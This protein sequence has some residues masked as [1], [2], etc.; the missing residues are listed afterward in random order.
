MYNPGADDQL[1]WLELHNE[2]AVNM[3]ISQWRIDGIEF[4]FPSR[5]VIPAGGYLVVAKSPTAL[6]SATGFSQAL[7]PYTGQLSNGGEQL[8]LINNNQRVMDAL[9]YDDAGEWPVGP[10]GSGASLAKINP[11]GGTQFV[12]NW[13]SSTQIGG[14]PGARNFTTG[15]LTGPTE[16]LIAFD[17]NWRYDQSGTD[18]GTDWLDAGF[19]P[20]DPNNDGSGLDA[21]GVGAGLLGN[22]TASLAEPIRT[23]V[24]LGVPTYYMR[25]EFNYEGNTG[26][27][28]LRL[29]SIVDDGAVFYL[30]GQEVS[31]FNMP[32]GTIEF[33]TP[34]VSAVR[35]ATNSGEI[36]IPTDAL[37]QGTNVL[38]VEVHQAVE[39]LVP[40]E[41]VILT[42]GGL[43]LVEE[44]P[45][46]P[47]AGSPAPDNLARLGTPFALDQLSDF[48]H[49]I[50]EINDGLYGNPSSW[51]GNGATG[52]SG[53]FVGI[54]L[55]A[56][57]MTLSSI[58]F[59]RSN[60]LAGDP[61][62][63]GVCTDR[64]LGL[65]RLQYT[66][67]ANPNQTT[68][69]SAWT[70]IGTLNYQSPGGT[71]FGFPHRRHLYSFNPVQATGIRLI[72]PTSGLGGGTAIDEIE[73]YGGAFTP[74][75]ELSAEGDFSLQLESEGEYSSPLSPALVPDNL[76]LST[77]G[78]STFGSGELT[79]GDIGEVADGRYGDANA[80]SS[81]G[82]AP[83][84]I[85]IDFGGRATFDRIAF[86]RDNGDN[87]DPGCAGGVCTDNA[88]GTYTLQL[89]D[90]VNPE[91]ST[92]DTG[93]RV[94]GWETI[95]TITYN[96]A[97]GNFAPHLRH[98]Y[99]VLENGDP[100]SARGIRILVSDPAM[101]IDEIEV[102]L[103]PEPQPVVISPSP[104]FN[105]NWDGN[106]GDFFDEAV[107]PNLALASGGTVPFGSG[108]LGAG[109]HLITA[110]NDGLYGNSNSWIGS[111]VSP[112]Y[113]GLNFGGP[114]AI[115][116]IA[117]GRDNG[118]MT[119]DACG[120]QCADRSLGTYT[121]QYTTVAGPGT[122]TTVTGD[123]S[124]GW[125]TVA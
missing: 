49:L 110:V 76:V 46:A 50:S 106:D 94:S 102:S 107:P 4:E 124:T 29:A 123:A 62:G 6:A 80:W 37:V 22:E 99:L 52:T 125:R 65:Y 75:Y 27:A 114:I 25:T 68:P 40:A 83:A 17:S 70:E 19:D 35:N 93:D 38:S 66:T 108:E 97:T 15:P 109:I 58:A 112:N 31:R 95:G 118:N 23:P 71:N 92:P 82:E 36:R 100:L 5:T 10:D 12:A 11:D 24:N 105:V 96:E 77:P 8:L 34:A 44:G 28:I 81:N 60:V 113:I 79:P 86:G 104:G 41:A 45:V 30:N 7:G 84:F 18:Y 115:D 1:E 3:D 53:P 98:E 88:L 43:T 26:A 90:I 63:G 116:R 91:T 69:D 33:T 32:A 117:W 42:N 67:T 56:T 64:T 20:D 74:P 14:T 39:D 120:G 9:T 89:T 72:V 78:A 87:T 73:L 13:T 121:L 51:I 59:G 103:T 48:G 47:T 16:T 85:G 111:G 101:T 57:P 55:G 122:G 61:C 119:T 21:W 2:M 54:N